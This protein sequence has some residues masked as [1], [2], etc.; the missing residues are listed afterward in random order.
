[1]RLGGGRRQRGFQPRRVPVIIIQ[2]L[3]LLDCFNIYLK[4]RQAGWLFGLQLHQVSVFAF[5]FVSATLGMCVCPLFP[6]IFVS[7]ADGWGAPSLN[8]GLRLLPRVSS[9][10]NVSW[11]PSEAQ[12]C[13]NHPWRWPCLQGVS[14]NG[15]HGA[16]RV[17]SLNL[18]TKPGS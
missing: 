11:Q 2:S 10:G 16:F 15:A 17:F 5:D 18:I 7:W 1:M 13:S 9:M 14:D 8:L 4:I 3:S 6:V 12:I